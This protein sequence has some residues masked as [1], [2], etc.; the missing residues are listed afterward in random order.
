MFAGKH[1]CVQELQYRTC[2]LC[3]LE[4]YVRDCGAVVMVPTLITDCDD[5]NMATPPHRY[6]DF[7]YGRIVRSLLDLVEDW[8][9]SS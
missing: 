6:L 7:M 1:A 3:R 8:G 2:H 5:T 4:K 9:R